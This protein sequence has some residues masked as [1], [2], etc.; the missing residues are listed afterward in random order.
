MD[1]TF[2]KEFIIDR[3]KND[4]DVN[5]KSDMYMML[6]SANEYIRVYSKTNSSLELANLGINLLTNVD[7]TYCQILFVKEKIL[8]FRYMSPDEDIPVMYVLREVD[9][10]IDDLN[11]KFLHDF[12]KEISA[13]FKL[14]DFVVVPKNNCKLS[15]KLIR[16]VLKRDILSKDSKGFYDSAFYCYTR[17]ANVFSRVVESDEDLDFETMMIYFDDVNLDKLKLDNLKFRL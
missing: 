11:Y 6:K 5:R 3:C 14:E 15:E 12:A 1:K 2:L 9:I 8:R 17:I 4:I 16:Q 7:T 13:L 10:K